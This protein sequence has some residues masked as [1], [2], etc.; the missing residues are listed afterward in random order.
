MKVIILVAGYATRLYPLTLNKPKALLPINEKPIID[1]IVDEIN[2]LKDADKIYVVS[3]HKFA[4]DFYNWAEN[5][6]NPIEIKVLDDGTTNEENRKGAIGDIY[7]AIEKEK[8]DDDLMVIAG[9]N[10]FTYKL[11]EYYDF[12][13]SINKDCICV[14]K[15]EDMEMI[16]QLGVALL[17]ENNKVLDLEEKPEKPKSNM[18]V[19]ATYIYLKETIPLFKKYLE[20]GNKPDAPGYFTSWLYKI[21]DLYAYKMNGDCFD[22]GTPKAYEDI[23]KMFK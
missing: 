13:K 12:F 5:K 14:K 6:D 18:A 4:D 8:I 21:K 1:Y 19:F 20:D 23:Q 17:D 10:F 2:T 7:Y 11:A 16:K 3:N 9:D 22:I 15:F